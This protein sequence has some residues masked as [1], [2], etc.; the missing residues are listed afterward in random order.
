MDGALEATAS[1]E[2]ALADEPPVA[3]GLEGT[4]SRAL[5][6]ALA[7]VAS[8]FGA[9]LAPTRT[10][11][12][13]VAILGSIVT[14]ALVLA[15]VRRFSRDIV[16]LAQ[17]AHRAGWSMAEPVAGPVAL[18]A[19]E[20]ARDE[21]A[22][23]ARKL[24]ERALLIETLL[25]AEEA[26]VE[27]LPD[28]LVLLGADRRIRRANEAARAAF[29]SDIAAVLRHP[30]LRAAIEHAAEQASS[31]RAISR[32]VELALGLPVER[33]VVATVIGLDPV[34][35]GGGRVLV[36]LSDRTRERAIERTRTDFIANASH[37]LRTPLTSLIGFIETLRG[38]ASDDPPAQARFLAIMAEQA[39]RMNRLID[40]L[41]SLSRIEISEHQ[42]PQ[43]RVDSVSLVTRVVAGFEPRVAARGQSL[44]I[45]APDVLPA[46]LADEDQLVQVVEN[47]LDNACKY[48]RLGGRIDVIAAMDDCLGPPNRAGVLISVVD[49][50]PGIARNHLPRLT[51]RFYRGDS[52]RPKGPEGTGL[53]LAIVKH[54]VNRHRG[55]LKIDSEPGQGTAVRI[56][57]PT[58]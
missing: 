47:L 45:D 16:H 4:L 40:D 49:D 21:I 19:T 14:I 55:V 44:T 20:L 56:W 58:A 38:S 25:G 36:V 26:I 17:T 28:P 32:R 6:I 1:G 8:L 27:R 48:G 23:L 37:E 33:D 41:L 39:A 52:G 10:V 31:R 34:L 24:S 50:G 29:G 51:E 54:I 12:V 15:G 13:T 11:A 53:G 5:M 42:P 3:G 35:P 2:R 22:R 57:L 43:G 18:P 7:P 46:I 30:S 9:A